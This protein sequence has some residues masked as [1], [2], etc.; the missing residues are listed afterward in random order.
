MQILPFL[1]W[2]KA[3]RNHPTPIWA[4]MLQ[5][6]GLT[7]DDVVG[8][9]KLALALHDHRIRTRVLPLRANVNP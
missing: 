6:L 3:H 7:K 4:L 5:L 8:D 1:A 2:S 9:H